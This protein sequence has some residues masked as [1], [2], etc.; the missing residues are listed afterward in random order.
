MDATEELP[1]KPPTRFLQAEPVP[2]LPASS[3]AEDLA[4]Q[5]GAP[6]V[7]YALGEWRENAKELF[8]V[9]LH[10][11][12]A[13]YLR[14]RAAN[15]GE[16]PGRHIETILRAFRSYHD[17]RRPEHRAATPEPGMPALTRRV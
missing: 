3:P 10:P 2:P 4:E 6:A 9:A 17:D 5:L 14:D 13:Q 16:V 11:R 1:A 7:D 12:H 15:H 8:V